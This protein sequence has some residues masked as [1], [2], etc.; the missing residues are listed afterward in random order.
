M[1]EIALALIYI[2]AVGIMAVMVAGFGV[3]PFFAAFGA[4]V[5][6][7]AA[8]VIISWATTMVWKPNN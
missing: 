7:P 2:V 5:P 1:T 8:I 4:D 3:V 6:F